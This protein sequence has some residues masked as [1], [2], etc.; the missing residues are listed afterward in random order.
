MKPILAV[1]PAVLLSS[2]AAFAMCMDGPPFH[3]VIN[4]KPGTRECV[5]GRLSAC[6]PDQSSPTGATGTADPRYAVL[7]VVYAP[8][9]TQGGKSASSVAYGAGSNTGTTTTA[10]GSFK[11]DYSV[12]VTAGGGILGSVEAGVSFDYNRSTTDSK[13]VEIKKSATTTISATGPAVDGIDHDRDIIYLWLNPALTLTVNGKDVSWNFTGTGTADI[14]Y[15]YIGWLK[16]T[17]AMPPGV[18]QRLALYGITPTD[19]PTIMARDPLAGGVSPS[20]SP[21]YQALPTTFP[22]EPPYAATDSPPTLNFVL[23]TA[24]TTTNGASTA[25]DYK[26]GLTV[27]GSESFLGI[28]KVTLKTDASWDWTNTAAKQ[29]AT[30]T[31]ESASVT[32][33]GPAFGYTGPTDMQVY[34]DSIYKTF[35]FEPLTGRAPSLTGRIAHNGNRPAAGVKVLASAKG[36]QYT[37]FT[38]AQGNYRF[39][40]P[41]TGPVQVQA[42]AQVHSLNVVPTSRQLNLSIP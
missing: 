19:Y 39:Y 35:A 24:S 10:T 26:V 33:T 15:V 12:S 28:E 17:I 9:G 2:Q 38:D 30:G 6:I 34:Y 42:G 7:S 5:G 27:S 1:L 37:T 31:S 11:Q 14:Q 32:I 4:G 8:P 40:A 20:G 21:R 29:V 16:G 36:L 18:T 25:D 41:L 23:T 3:C 13:A 22:Y